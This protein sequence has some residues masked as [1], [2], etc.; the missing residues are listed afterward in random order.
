MGK[1][2]LSVLLIFAYE[3]VLLAVGGLASGG[4]LDDRLHCHAHPAAGQACD[5]KQ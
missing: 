1:F 3:C 4:P 5:R 2:M